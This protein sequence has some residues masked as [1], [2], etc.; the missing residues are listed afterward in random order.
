VRPPVSVIVPARDAAATLPDLL[1]ALAAQDLGTP[2]EVVA[3]DDGSSDATRALLQGAPAVTRV[4][5]GGGRGPAHARNLAAA[6]ASGEVL[7]FTDADCAPA[8]DW[9]R[10]GLAALE[11]GADVVQGRV[12][13]PPD[14]APGPFDR[15]VGVGRL[16]HLYETANLLV[17]RPWFDR[18][19][20]FEPGWLMPGRT[21]ELGEDVWL[22]WKLRRAG[23]RVAFAPEVHVVH[24]VFDR[25]PRDFVA[26]RLRLR[27]F[28]EI[29]RRVPELRTEFFWGRLF[30]NARTAQF[31][32][33]LAG[34]ALAAATRRPWPLLAAAP[35]ARTAA[36][37]ALWRGGRRGAV[38]VLAV[39]V[40]AD[41][42]G[43]GALVAGSV[44]RRSILL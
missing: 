10:R 28:P 21:K 23:A 3:V 8:P 41:A 1:A 16:S 42:V 19:G 37:H 27:F 39:D 43:A 5:D 13:P 44:A 36:R 26:E 15:T 7:A 25:S 6:A 2:F 18:V 40:A 22:G 33:A 34:V 14:A 38:K 31:D 11:A 17:R 9:L 30:L 4:L 32:A 24:A 20:G 35:Y 12:T 29:A